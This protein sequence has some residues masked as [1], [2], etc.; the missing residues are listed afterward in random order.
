DVVARA[1]VDEVLIAIPSASGRQ[2]RRIVELAS[3]AGVRCRI[4]P[5]VLDILNGDVDVS[6]IREVQVQDLLRR[7]PIE[8][9]RASMSGYLTD[10]VVL[11]TGGGGSIGSEI[12]RQIAA[13]EPRKVLLLGRGENS[14]HAIAQELRR[15]SP[16]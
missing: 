9:D 4:L 3:S 6:H 12:V 10:Q 7:E 15:E 1:N 2:T 11:V 14:L 13:F 16:D 5:G 8:L